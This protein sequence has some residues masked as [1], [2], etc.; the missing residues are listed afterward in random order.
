MTER[1]PTPAPDAER[2]V[3]VDVPLD[4]RRTLGIHGRG[5]ADPALRFEASGSTWRVSRTPDG[6]VTMLVELREGTVR[7]RAWGPGAAFALSRLEALLGLDD[8]PAALV[9]RHHGRRRRRCAVCAA[10]GSGGPER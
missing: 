8:D 5:T 4:L 2:I 7:G 9:P 10:C 3:A 1:R 6:P